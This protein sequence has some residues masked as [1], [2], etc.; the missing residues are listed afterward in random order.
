MRSSCYCHLLTRAQLIGRINHI[1]IPRC[2]G[3]GQMYISTFLSSRKGRHR[4]RKV[5]LMYTNQL[6]ISTKNFHNTLLMSASLSWFFTLSPILAYSSMHIIIV[7]FTLH[8]NHVSMV[9]FLTR[10]SFLKKSYV[11]CI[12]SLPRPNTV[13]HRS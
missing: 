12:F 3:A 10:L 5:E 4:R 1:Q 7:P 2:K 13:T 6:T 11:F 8:Y 9:I